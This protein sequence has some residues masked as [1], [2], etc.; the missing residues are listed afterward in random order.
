MFFLPL[1]IGIGD[2]GCPSV[3]QG[4]ED[5]EQDYQGSAN[6]QESAGAEGPSDHACI[7][8]RIAFAQYV[9][10]VPERVSQSARAGPG[11]SRGFLRH[12]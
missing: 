10:G 6:C 2:P 11:V 1:N 4:A 5:G 8:T 9:C 3:L 12:A 7:L